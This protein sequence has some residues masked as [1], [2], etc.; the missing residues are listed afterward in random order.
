M[1]TSTG[2]P[3]IGGRGARDAASPDTGCET[4]GN[5]VEPGEWRRCRRCR[6]DYG[7]PQHRPGER[8]YQK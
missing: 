2:K 5:P 7:V 3:V 4:C 6:L 8:L 1:G